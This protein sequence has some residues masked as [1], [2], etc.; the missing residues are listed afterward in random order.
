MLLKS[1]VLFRLLPSNTFRCRTI[2]ASL[3]GSSSCCFENAKPSDIA[4]YKEAFAK[5]MAMAGLKPH[6]RVALG[7]SG[8]PDSIALCI[9]ALGWK[10]DALVGM[11]ETSSCI[12]GIVGI[13]VDHKLRSESTEEANHVR[14]TVYRMGIRCEIAQCDWSEGRP[15]P[16]H[17]QE[18]AR[19]MRYQLLREFCIQHQIG[20]L[21]IAH[22]ADDQAELF[23]LRLSRNS[24]VLGLAGMAFT[25][26]SFPACLRCF[27][28]DSGNH[29]ILLVR[30][31]LDFSKEDMYNYLYELT[32]AQTNISGAFRSELLAIISACRKTRRNIDRICCNLIHQT[33]IIM[34]QGYAII[35]LEKLDPSNVDELYLSRFLALVLQV[36]RGA[37]IHQPL[38]VW[39]SIQRLWHWI[40]VNEKL[41]D[42][43]TSPIKQWRVGFVKSGF[44]TAFAAA[45]CYLCAAP[46]SKGTR[47]LISVCPD[48]P[49]P[50]KMG[51]S[52][53]Y[54][55][56]GQLCSLPSEIGQ[57]LVEAKSYSD[58]MIPETS[59]VPFL[60]LTSSEFILIEA[61]K[62]NIIS[63]STHENI[64]LLQK[65]ECENFSAKRELKSEHD[66][67]HHGMKSA[68]AV[69]VSLECGQS[70]HFMNRF[71]V[72]W[73]ICEKTTEERLP[74]ATD[75]K[76][77][78]KGG[79]Q[80]DIYESCVT[81]QGREVVI[82][83]MVDADW[84]YL[85]KLSKG[86]MT[87]ESLDQGISS[88]FK[89]NQKAARAIP[90]SDYAQLSALRALDILKSIPASVRRGMPV[91]VDHHGLLLSIPVRCSTF[92]GG[93]TQ[94]FLDPFFLK[95]CRRHARIGYLIC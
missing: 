32:L 58:Q 88:A 56:E 50:F 59:D 7:V 27:G 20:V 35:D 11:D 39:S 21:L 74:M 23:I 89:V 9:L 19:E 79:N 85:S 93:V 22:H 31:L 41:P 36:V 1:P 30:P 38:S 51:L 34:D 90:C 15:K 43:G 13:V 78:L 42:C 10:K 33:L 87:E 77:H 24:G 75:S 80:D 91:L 63:E 53:T 57:I 14:N 61:R 54:P 25:S 28:K 48:S 94:H 86:Q 12:N 95:A 5:R 69:N 2:S 26:Q 70:C 65:E 40:R 92:F 47:I 73:D 67:M 66:N 64:L 76:W 82:R 84:L 62:M 29:G 44:Q 4:K 16:G 52:Q 6:H 71:W 60:H 46:G 72:R 8:G 3:S 18:A 17:L 49:L 81:C 55:L 45:G 68:N 83:Y 37:V